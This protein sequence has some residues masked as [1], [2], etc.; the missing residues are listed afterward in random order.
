MVDDVN[1]KLKIRKL[2]KGVVFKTF[3]E[4]NTT[5]QEEKVIED[6]INDISNLLKILLSKATNLRS[7]QNQNWLLWKN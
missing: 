5:T 6:E 2:L 1:K 4:Y 3:G 7:K